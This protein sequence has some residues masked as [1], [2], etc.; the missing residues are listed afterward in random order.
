MLKYIF[1]IIFV[2]TCLQQDTNCSTQIFY[3]DEQQSTGVYLSSKRLAYKKPTYRQNKKVGFDDVFFIM[4]KLDKNSIHW[5]NY[6]DIMDRGYREDRNNTYNGVSI[7]KSIFNLLE[8]QDFELNQY[9]IWIAFAT[10]KN[11]HDGLN[12][13][14]DVEISLAVITDNQSPITTHAGIFRNSN[15]FDLRSCGHINVAMQ[16]HG[17]AAAVTKT[18][19]KR[20]MFMVTNGISIMKNLLEKELVF[21]EQIWYENAHQRF[22]SPPQ[23]I[24]SN[25]ILN[26]NIDD[27][28]N[29]LHKEDSIDINQ[30]SSPISV[31]ENDEYINRTP[32][33]N[34]DK[35]NWQIKNKDGNWIVFEKPRWF[36]VLNQANNV[37]EYI[38]SLSLVPNVIVSISALE[39]IWMSHVDTKK[40]NISKYHF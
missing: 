11:P 3:S 21:G 17:F 8:T 25:N 40:I 27:K 22:S 18:L 36:D 19:Y 4:E 24:I 34:R 5:K 6:A 20:K 10:R 12:L 39:K 31:C 26:S 37:E 14:K 29:Q 23:R 16:L 28:D 2:L 32:F 35:L 7:F 1:T 9:N 33:D 13:E 38:D 30:L 15:Y